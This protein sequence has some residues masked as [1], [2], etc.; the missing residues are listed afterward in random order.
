LAGVRECAVDNI[1]VTGLHAAATEL[2]PTVDTNVIGTGHA[3]LDDQK[4]DLALYMA[5]RAQAGASAQVRKA[6]HV[7]RRGV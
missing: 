7:P 1:A 4:L 6:G 2:T 5:E 3:L